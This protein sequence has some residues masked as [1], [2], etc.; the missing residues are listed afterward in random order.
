MTDEEKDTQ[1]AAEKKAADEKAAGEEKQKQEEAAKSKTYTQAE[2]DSG[3][4]KRVTEAVQ[5]R[6]TNLKATWEEERKAAEETARLEGQGEFKAL[7]EQGEAKNAKL[8]E[9]VAAMTT[10]LGEQVEAAK[11]NEQKMG[12]FVDAEFEKLKVAPAITDLLEG[13]PP[14]ERLAWLTKHRQDIVTGKGLPEAA[15]ADGDK[16]LSDEQKREQSVGIRNIW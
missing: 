5:T 4:D 6:E 13:K 8:T 14:L 11:T 1:Q 10:Q 15:K 12:E 7:H 16:K 2:F 3:V 9:Q